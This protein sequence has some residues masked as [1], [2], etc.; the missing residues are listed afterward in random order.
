[1]KIKI[2]I[3]TLVGGKS[4]KKVGT[5][6][7]LLKINK[8]H[9]D[10]CN[11]LRKKILCVLSMSEEKKMKSQFFFSSGRIFTTSEDLVDQTI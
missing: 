9:M 10:L 7:F 3:L 4:K 5:L 2:W 6:L 11:F 8:V 1:M